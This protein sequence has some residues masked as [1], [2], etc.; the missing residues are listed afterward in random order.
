MVG[1]RQGLA[2][3]SV[4]DPWP[5]DFLVAEHMASQP[6]K[7]AGEDYRGCERDSCDGMANDGTGNMDVDGVGV[8]GGV[9]LATARGAATERGVGSAQRNSFLE[10]QGGAGASIGG[11]AADRTGRAGA[12]PNVATEGS[13]ERQGIAALEA[14]LHAMLQRPIWSR[15]SPF[16]FFYRFLAALGMRGQVHELPGGQHAG[17]G[18]LCGDIAGAESALL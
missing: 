14:S 7:L 4:Y 2:V 16:S 8:G 18:R 13:N 3:A 9:T 1:L 11:A 5:F 15:A 6:G 10:L 12:A 17:A